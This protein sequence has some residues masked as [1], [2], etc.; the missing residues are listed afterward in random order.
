M[1][2]NKNNY[3]NF[4]KTASGD[5]ANDELRESGLNFDYLETL[6][7]WQLQQLSSKINTISR[8]C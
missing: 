6:T 8:G 5:Q 4:S 2:N 1:I 3:L 7:I